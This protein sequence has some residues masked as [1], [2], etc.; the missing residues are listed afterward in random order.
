MHRKLYRSQ[1]NPGLSALQNEHQPKVAQYFSRINF[2]ILNRLDFDV[3]ILFRSLRACPTLSGWVEKVKS[4]VHAANEDALF[5]NK[6]RRAQNR[7]KLKVNTNS[8]QGGEGSA[9]VLHNKRKRQSNEVN[10]TR[11]SLTK[12]N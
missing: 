12:I 11:A 6:V 10:I 3:S 7:E 8:S 4:L 2:S 1:K 9:L 5:L